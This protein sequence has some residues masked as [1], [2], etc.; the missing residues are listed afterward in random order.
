MASGVLGGN[1]AREKKR[2]WEE[3]KKVYTRKNHKKFKN[4]HHALLPHQSL[5]TKDNNS[6]SPLPQP[7]LARTFEVV[8]SDDSSSHNHPQSVPHNARELANGNAFSVHQDCVEFD[9]ED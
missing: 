9:E 7:Q 6:S 8:A 5:T 1:E 2:R 4:S 3:S